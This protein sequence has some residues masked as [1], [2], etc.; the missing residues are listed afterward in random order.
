L[1]AAKNRLLHEFI[2]NNL[3]PAPPR[4]CGITMNIDQNGIL[5]IEAKEEYCNNVKEV[6]IIISA[7][8]KVIRKSKK[9]CST[10][11]FTKLRIDVL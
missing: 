10:A 9:Y 6:K 1:E 2:L 11:Q 4:Q 8:L 7:A 5:T 3:T